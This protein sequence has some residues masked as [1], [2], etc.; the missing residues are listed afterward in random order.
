MTDRLA[1]KG[2]ATTTGGHI[3]NGSSTFYNEKGQPFAL[4]YDLATCGTC[5]GTFP[6]YGT[7][8]DCYENGKPMVKHQDLVMCP[9][10]NNRVFAS[11][12][13]MVFLTGSSSTAPDDTAAVKTP[14]PMTISFD[15]QVRANSSGVALD[16]YPYFI[17]TTDGLT[18]SGSTDATGLLP[19][20]CTD[21]SDC[22]TVYWGDDALARPE[23]N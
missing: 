23:G 20:I 13:S 7:V 12:A 11:R 9:C 18:Y 8:N 4:K 2:D 6:I 15:E 17:E 19:R 16:D 5:K 10:G 14:S 3:L 22:Y 21:A 1:A